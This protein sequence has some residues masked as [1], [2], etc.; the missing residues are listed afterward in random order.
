MHVTA[1]T[2]STQLGSVSFGSKAESKSFTMPSNQISGN[3]VAIT[4]DAGTVHY[5][6]LYTYA[7]SA[8]APGNLTAF[9]VMR[10]LYEPGKPKAFAT[11]DLASPGSPLTMHPGRVI[12]IGIR[13]AVDHPVDRV[14][15]EDPLPAGFEAID[16]SFATSIQSVV[17]QSDNWEIEGRL[18]YRDRVLAFAPHLGPGVY[19]MHYLV[20]SVTPGMYRWPGARVYLEDAPEEFGRSANATL[21][22]K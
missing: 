17:P 4:S 13:F 22:L 7:V 6:L 19:E 15:I 8:D 20:R 18:I 14:V 5:V 21:T 2:G 12:D 3:D 16:T 9:R 1:R 10:Q 11:I